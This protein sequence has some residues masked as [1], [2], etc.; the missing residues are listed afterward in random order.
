MTIT[1]LGTGTLGTALAREFTSRGLETRTVSR[2]EPTGQLPPG[3][4]H[5]RADADNEAALTAALA[6]SDVVVHT[7]QPAYHR[8]E[9]EFPALQRAIVNAAAAAGAK[10]VIADNLYMYGE[11]DDG[12]ITDGTAELPCSAKGRVRK[13]MADEALVAHNDGR[14]EVALTRPSNYVGAGYALTQDLLLNP[15]RAAKAMKVLGAVDQPHSFSYVP[16]VARAMAD[17]ALAGDAYG[18]PW[19]LPSMT[20]MTQRE[21]CD[22]LWT[23]VG[24]EG[25]AKIQALR[26]LG[27]RVIGVFN[28]PLRA[29]VEMLYEFEKPF[30]SQA[31]DFEKRFGWTAT[32]AAAALGATAGLKV[33]AN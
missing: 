21:L 1:I 24:N 11:G 32:A 18:R 9:Q 22:A 7:A 31:T 33:P 8:W 17:I 12:V 16:D 2:G 26:G 5:T 4:G 14:L 13:A 6:G 20:P 29:S 19:I 28:A 30:I 15:A 3:V 25:P 27:A 23:A 10:L